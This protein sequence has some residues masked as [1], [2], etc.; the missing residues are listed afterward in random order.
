VNAGSILHRVR[1]RKRRLQKRLDRDNFPE[2]DR[3]DVGR[4]IAKR[5]AP[6]PAILLAIGIGTCLFKA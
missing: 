4:T 3:P 6:P 2:G 1:A 5:A